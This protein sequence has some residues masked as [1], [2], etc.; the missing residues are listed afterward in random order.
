MGS[1]SKV[2][3]VGATSLIVGVYAIS[4]K[5][6]QTTGMQTAK[7]QV[8]RMQNERLVDAALILALDKVKNTG[9]N[10]NTTVSG[11]QA[12]GGDITYTISHANGDRATIQMTVTKGDFSKTVKATVEKI[13][14]FKVN[15]LDKQKQGFRKLHRGDWQLT[16]LFV[17]H[18]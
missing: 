9:G 11:A 5:N 3:L 7:S 1:S 17:G 4:L 15:G 13:S 8:D 10:I 18:S 2:L 12:L 14:R 6:V 16:S